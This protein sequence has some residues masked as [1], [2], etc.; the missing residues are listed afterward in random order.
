REH[1]MWT[2]VSIAGRPAEVFTPGPGPYRDALIYLHGYAGESLRDHP[3][4]ERL[5]ETFQL[6]VVAP[7]G[8]QCWWLDTLCEDFSRERAPMAYVRQD[9]TSWIETHWQVAPPRVALLG[10]SMG[11]QGVLNL[12]YRHALK[13][14]VVAAISPAIDY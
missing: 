1:G 8:K 5:F 14:P 6:Q 4:F 2:T 9:V 7:Q 3:E 10:I 13:F 11:G 12:A